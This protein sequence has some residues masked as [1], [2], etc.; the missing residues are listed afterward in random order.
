MYFQHA[1]TGPRIRNR[2][3]LRHRSADNHH[4]HWMI[5]CYLLLFFYWDAWPLV[6]SYSHAWV[7]WVYH[8]H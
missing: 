4:I 2:E 5:S 1:V 6:H 3:F 7:E 8:V